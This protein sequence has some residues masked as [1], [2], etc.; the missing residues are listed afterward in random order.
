MIRLDPAYWNNRYLNND[1][2]WDVGYPSTPL[3]TY[4][5]QLEDR[6]ISVLTPGAG[7]AYEAGYL[8]EK[9]FHKV[10][11]LDFAE[12]PLKKFRESYPAFPKPQLH[13]EDFFRHQGRYDLIIE[14]T[15]FCALDPSLRADYAKHMHAL[16][17][18]GG[19]LAGV[20]FN[21]PLNTGHPP[22]GGSSEE[23]KPY[24]EPYFHFKTYDACYNSIKPREGREWF[25][26]LQKK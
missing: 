20:L 10:H 18:P 22:F 14:Q 5:D 25:I 7:N 24:F 21:A 26:I 6:S 4:I 12:E 15:F 16:L 2:V 19:K 23:Y 8:F 3:K 17:K 1:F 13:Q 9:G 11:V